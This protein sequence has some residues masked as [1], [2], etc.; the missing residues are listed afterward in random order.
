MSTKSY[1]LLTVEMR[2]AVA[3]VGLNRPD[4]RNAINDP[5]IDEICDVFSAPPAGARV[6]VLH[7]HGTHFSAGLDLAEHRDRE[8]FEVMQHSQ[9]W[10]RTFQYVQMG[11]LPVVTA[12]KGAVVGG[13]LELATSTH[14]R[15]AEPSTFYALP[16]GSRGIFVGGGGS[17]RI[18]RI[19]GA[20][21]MAEMMLT[22]H[23]YNAQEGQAMGLSHHLVGEGEALPKALELAERIASNAP[24]SNYAVINALPRIADMAQNDG[25]FAE[26]LMAAMTQTSTEARDRMRAF[27]EGKAPKAGA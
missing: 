24:L 21:R 23:A 4:K 8:A 3:V 19:I 26:S 13:G 18:A 9:K 14:V 17:V 11:G 12:L 1:A 22:G 16:E 6:I 5:L 2:G 10:H 20:G 25:L 15:V 7:G 27:L